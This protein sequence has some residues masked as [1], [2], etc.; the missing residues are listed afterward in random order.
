MTSVNSLCRPGDNFFFPISRYV[1]C[2]NRSNA[3]AI[4]NCSVYDSSK[5][6]PSLG[7][8]F[9]SL[10]ITL[11]SL[12]QQLIQHVLY[13]SLP[14][15]R[16]YWNSVTTHVKKYCGKK[17]FSPLPVASG[18]RILSKWPRDL[19]CFVTKFLCEKTRKGQLTYFFEQ[20]S[21][22]SCPYHV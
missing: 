2:W 18:M 8:T 13:N 10:L 11:I 22:K 14:S 19:K 15:H 1:S 21:L 7:I 12:C 5:L 16:R 20:I 4:Q 3:V 17:Y 6:F 9:Q